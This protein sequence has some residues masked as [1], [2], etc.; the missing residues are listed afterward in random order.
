MRKNLLVKNSM[1]SGRFCRAATFEIEKTVVARPLMDA[2][3]HYDYDY[4]AEH[5]R[6][7]DGP[8]LFA[9]NPEAVHYAYACRNEEK[10]EIMHEE[11]GNALD[12]TK[13]DDTGFQGGRKSDHAYDARW[14]WYTCA[15]HNQFSQSQKGE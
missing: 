14:Q 2:A 3:C 13:P 11:I 12:L 5:A 10:S 8:P 7:Y 4:G 1:M 6:G 15:P 9:Q